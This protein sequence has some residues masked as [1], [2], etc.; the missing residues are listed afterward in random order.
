MAVRTC[1]MI[2]SRA[3]L[4]L[5]SGV[6][7]VSFACVVLMGARKPA[8]DAN[9]DQ[10]TVHRINVVEPDGTTRLVISDRASFPGSYFLGKELPRTDREATG[11]IFNDEEGTESGGL[12][13]GG[14]KDEQGVPHSWGH[15]SFDQSQRD[16]TTVIES[17]HDGPSSNVYYSINDDERAYPLGPAFQADWQ[18]VKAMPAGP[19]RTA[20]GKALR[21]KY[22]G[23]LVNRVYLGRGRDRGVTL[24]LKDQ[25][26]RAR[27]VAS[28][29][30]DGTPKIDFLDEHGKVIKSIGANAF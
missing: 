11:M 14:K 28:V 3:F 15:L 8:A 21:E 26:G 18:R 30:P 1:R 24:S 5:Y 6:L 27:L 12:I 13:F 29:T 10:I 23:G 2:S 25:Q 16:Q 19:E 7:T 17:N 20:A 4:A 22:P 9:F